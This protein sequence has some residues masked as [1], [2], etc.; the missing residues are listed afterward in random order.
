MPTVGMEQDHCYNDGMISRV[1][2]LLGDS[3]DRQVK[4]LQGLVDRIGALEPELQRLPDDGL[5]GMTDSF[6]LRLSRGATL[7]DLL[8]EAF[9]AVREASRRTI[10]LRHFDVQLIGG[11][12]LHQGKVA[13]MKTGEGK[14]LAA[15]LPLYLN[16]LEGRGA[17]LVTVNDYLARRDT[18]WMGPVYHALGLTVGTLQHEGASLFDPLHARHTEADDTRLRPV[19]RAEAYAADITYGT[20]NEFGFDYLRDNMVVRTEDRVQR[21][22]HYAIVDEVDNILI[23]EARTPLIISG[24]A[25]ESTRAYQAIAQLIPQLVPER[26]FVVEEKHRTVVLTDPGMSRVEGLLNLGN[27]YDPANAQLIH[28]I[29]NALKAHA[30]FQ[31]DKHYVVRSG[32]VVIVDEFTGRLQEGR[33]FNDGLHQAL[34]AKERVTV[35]QESVT[36]ATITLQ[37]FF[38]MYPKLGGMTGTAVT[39]AEELFK[40]YK[41]EVVVVPT[42]R[43]V[44]RQDLP[45]LV[46]KT[47]AAKYRAV[48]EQIAKLHAEGKPVLVGTTSIERSEHLSSALRHRG[49]PHEVLNAKQ[50]EREAQVVAQA[51]QPKAVTV[52]TNMAG[53][54]TDIILGGDPAAAD[55]AEDWQRA[56]DEVVTAGGLQIVGTERHESRRIDNQLRGRAGRQGDPGTTYF[57]GSLEDDIIRR[58]GGDRIRGLMN[59]MGLPEDVPLESRLVSKVMDSTQ[60]KVEANNFDIRKHLVEYDDVVNTQRAIIYAERLK[61]I[62]GADLKPHIEQIVAD[63]LS[64]LARDYLRGEDTDWEIDVF[65]LEASR[66]LPLPQGFDAEHVLQVGAEAA[67]QELLETAE[68]LYRE[69]EDAFGSELMRQ[70]ERA[71]LLQTVDRLWVQHL[72]AMRNLR[73]GIGLYAYGQRDP[74]VMYKKEGFDQFSMLQARIRQE[75]ARIFLHVVPPDRAA[76]PKNG[77]STSTVKSRFGAVR[78]GEPQVGRAPTT[79]LSRA[80][81]EARP[82]Q[83]PDPQSHE[84][85]PTAPRWMR[86]Q[87]ARAAGKKKKRKGQG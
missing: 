66:I 78:S 65:L 11:A 83:A 68:A 27:L 86:R 28:H 40:V 23:D 21:G 75:I 31:R 46:Y 87:A 20:N 47:E 72:T 7:D 73:E 18:T 25:Q 34:E 33:R 41:L 58:F 61:A 74:L 16:A 45:D 30:I 19:G 22:L 76:A 62:D 60:A 13:E 12:V 54:G 80:A 44:T 39:E 42:H 79:V 69:R 29:E 6:R 52:A 3:N 77:R 35:R 32:E 53:R 8:P 15:T 81:A 9:A 71:L 24:P 2:R 17:H 37:N 56:H 48:V 1:F 43:P 4:R 50:H 63:E 55:S 67:G 59:F 64:T 10:G 84:V 82:N 49:I 26:D 57:F 85:D 5:R 70:I 36:Y 51:G 14:T 38:R